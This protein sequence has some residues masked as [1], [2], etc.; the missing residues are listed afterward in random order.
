LPIGATGMPKNIVILCDGTSNEISEDRTNIL[1]LFG[2]LTKSDDQVVFYD[3]GVGTFGASNS[4]SYYFRKFV[5]LW[6]RFSGWGLDANVKEAYRFLVE[7][8]DHGTEDENGERQPDGIFL[9]GFSRGA[10]TVRVLA[11]FIHTVGLLHPN[12]LNLLD[13]A[14]RAYKRIG[15]NHDRRQSDSDEAAFAEVRLYE[16]MLRSVRPRIAC[17]GLFDTVGSVFES[18]RFGCRL[19]SHAFTARNRSVQAVRHA[20]A[21]DEKRTMFQPQLW[22]AG[23]RFRPD[24]FQA[25][26]ETSQ[27]VKEVWF[28][29][30]HGDV[31]GGYPESKSQLAK[32][33][34]HWMIKE[35]RSLGLI[36]KTGTIN[37][38]VLGKHDK[39]YVAPDPVAP[40]N[41]SM[42]FG[43]SIIEF[44]P[45]R[46][47]RTGNVRRWSV[48][49]WYVPF[50]EP[51]LVPD[52]ATLHGSVEEH[53]QGP[54]AIARA[55][56]PSDKAS[57]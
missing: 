24:H 55:H 31:G 45:R 27:D 33:P 16:R 28:V 18:G 48:L 30:S 47:P 37:T 44:L 46:R 21:L 49:G 7:H 51:R 13:Y 15:E 57:V 1:R 26:S 9:F 25:K 54:H 41:N 52:E 2:T 32:I 17:L 34:L 4:A 40:I 8:Y 50:F 39:K 36:F 20:V 19:R 6:G 35:T 23:G 42:T 12:N 10:Y 38:I 3:P 22:P 14:Y 11:G 43:W 53:D 29:G 5:E 56:A